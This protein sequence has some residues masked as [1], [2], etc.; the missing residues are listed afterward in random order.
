[1]SAPLLFQI[2]IMSKQ[3]C[4][5]P[6]RVTIAFFQPGALAGLGRALTAEFAAH[7]Q[8]VDLGDFDLEQLLNSL[9]DFRLVRARIGHDGVLIK[10]LALARALSQSGG[11]S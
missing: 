7:V 2:L 10:F 5:L 8:R 9:T 1:M 3:S 11:R 6:S 4:R